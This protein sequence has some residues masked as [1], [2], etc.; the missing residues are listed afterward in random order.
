MGGRGCSAVVKVSLQ[1]QEVLMLMPLDFGIREVH[2]L[3]SDPP[4]PTKKPTS[5]PLPFETI[6]LLPAAPFL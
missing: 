1:S 2:F 6:Q 3:Q 5:Y 4:V